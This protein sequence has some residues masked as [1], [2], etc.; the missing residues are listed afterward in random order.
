MHTDSFLDVSR[1][2]NRFLY[3][4]CI[5]EFKMKGYLNNFSLMFDFY[6]PWKPLVFWRFQGLQKCNIGLKWVK[7]FNSN[8]PRGVARNPT[9]ICDG[10]LWNNNEHFLAVNCCCTALH[11]RR[12]QEFIVSSCLSYYTKQSSIEMICIAK[13]LTAYSRNMK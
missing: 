9:D 1:H 6:I 7:P 13:L 10:E 2:E 5:F 4:Y 8:L 3:I 12:F 11:R